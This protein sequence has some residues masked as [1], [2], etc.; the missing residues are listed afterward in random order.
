MKL[1]VFIK[2]TRTRILSSAYPRRRR[3]ERQEAYE[4]TDNNGKCRDK[5]KYDKAVENDRVEEGEVSL[6]ERRKTARKIHES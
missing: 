2:S 1:Q 3:K 5:T 6:C 4:Q